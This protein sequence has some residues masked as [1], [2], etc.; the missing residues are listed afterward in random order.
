MKEACLDLEH[1][2]PPSHSFLETEQSKISEHPHDRADILRAHR[3]SDQLLA[4][5]KDRKS[6]GLQWAP[7]P[8]PQPRPKQALVPLWK[9]SV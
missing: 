4:R 3:F 1:F 9:M 2:S 7:D 6:R 8:W 5:G